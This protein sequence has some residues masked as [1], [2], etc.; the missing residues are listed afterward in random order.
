[1]DDLT[2][3][4]DVVCCHVVLGDVEWVVELVVAD[5]PETAAYEPLGTLDVVP[6]VDADDV[7]L[8]VQRL[9]AGLVDDDGCALWDGGCH[10]VASGKQRCEGVGL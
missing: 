7:D 3:D 6:V 4:L 2:A 1:M 9:I 5:K 8:A 10:G